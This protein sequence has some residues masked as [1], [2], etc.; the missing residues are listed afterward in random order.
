MLDLLGEQRD[1][2]LRGSARAARACRA[3]RRPA[4]PSTRGTNR[5]GRRSDSPANASVMPKVCVERARHGAQPGAAARAAACRRYQTG[6]VRVFIQIVSSEGQEARSSPVAGTS[7][8]RWPPIA[9][10]S[11]S[12][13]VIATARGRA[14]C[15][16]LAQ[17]GAERGDGVA[18]QRRRR[19]LGDQQLRPERQRARQVHAHLHLGRRP[20][21]PAG[22]TAP[23]RC[24]PR[25]PAR[26]P[27]A[28]RADRSDRR[29]A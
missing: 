1:V 24:R 5:C 13:A 4:A 10:A 26:R 15:A 23:G 27:A 29:R 7:S 22:R 18:R 12:S 6:S 3:G 17:V 19:M 20:C 14:T 16:T 2:G 8:R 21:P 28:P 25:A 9:F 11:A